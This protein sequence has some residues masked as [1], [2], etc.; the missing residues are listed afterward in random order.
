MH[1][2]FGLINNHVSLVTQVTPTFE[3][4]LHVAPGHLSVS[5]HTLYTLVTQTKDT[6][7]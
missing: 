2:G 3:Y 6:N 7:D 1:T 5:S 4:S